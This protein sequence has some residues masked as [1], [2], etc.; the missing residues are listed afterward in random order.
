MTLAFPH[1]FLDFL[2]KGDRR[3]H[4]VGDHEL[5][6]AGLER[7]NR[8]LRELSPQAPAITMDQI[9]GAAKIK[10]RKLRL[11]NKSEQKAL[12]PY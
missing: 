2:R 5:E 3:R 12:S 10:A 8:A 1:G 11:T 7:F 6:P 9:A 4:R